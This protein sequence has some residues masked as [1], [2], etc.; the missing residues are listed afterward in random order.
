MLDFHDRCSGDYYMRRTA[1]RKAVK[2]APS[3]HFAEGCGWGEE[4]SGEPGCYWGR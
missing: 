4:F 2:L 1:E 3:T